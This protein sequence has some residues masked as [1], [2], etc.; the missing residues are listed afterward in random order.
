MK[1]ETTKLFT[2]LQVAICTQYGAED[3][4]K[5]FAITGPQEE[6]LLGA[7]QNHNGFLGLINYITVTDKQG[8]KVFAGMEQTVTGRK[9]KAR[10][11]ADIPENGGKYFCADTD[12]GIAIPWVRMDVWARMGAKFRQLYATYVQKQIGL[13][14]MMIGW[15]GRE[16]AATTNPQ[17]KPKLQDVN[18]GWMQWMR[19]NK[20]SNIVTEGAKAGEIRIFGNNSDYANLD[21]LAYDMRMGLGEAHRERGDLV[22]LVGADLVAKEASLISKTNGLKPTEKGAMKQ[23][24]LMGTFGGLPAATP[25]H[26]PATGAVITTYQNLS[27]YIQSGSWRRG[28]K[29]NDDKKQVEDKNYRNEA[30]VVEDES[31]FVGLEFDNVRLPP[32]APIA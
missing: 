27:I 7:I 10:F 25:P 31:L 14:Q 11:M 21:E 16:V 28:I 13:D 9:P 12:S 15:H 4:T 1:L 32:H 23:H 17:T 29:D 19:D 3:A 26:F 6:R 22:F 30:Y 20:A 2:A 24:E 18:K 5:M 8:E